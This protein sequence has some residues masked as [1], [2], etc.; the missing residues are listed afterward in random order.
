VDVAPPE[1]KRGIDSLVEVGSS[2]RDGVRD[3]ECDGGVRTAMVVVG[4]GD[5]RDGAGCGAAGSC[6]VAIRLCNE[7]ADTDE[8][9]SVVFPHRRRLS[10]DLDGGAVDSSRAGEER[11]LRP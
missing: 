7:L 5:L 2:G 11:S 8:R 4:G 9:E 1:E 10:R 6:E 3:S